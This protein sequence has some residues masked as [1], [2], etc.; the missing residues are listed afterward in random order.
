LSIR[1][2]AD[3]ELWAYPGKATWYFA[4]LPA[5]LT[6]PL[7]AVRGPS[8]G[9]GSIRVE[10]TIGGSTWKTSIFPDS[11]SGTFLL[12]V[13]VRKQEAISAGDCVRLIVEIAL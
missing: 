10:A 4:S 13:K 8:S 7:K 5:D 9:W 6:E 11:K 12:P 2:E 3:C 1:Y